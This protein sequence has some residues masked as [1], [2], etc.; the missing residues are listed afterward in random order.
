MFPVSLR[1][2]ERVSILVLVPK[3]TSVTRFLGM[4]WSREICHDWPSLFKTLFQT[5]NMI[6]FQLMIDDSSQACQSFAV[7]VFYPRLLNE[8]SVKLRLHF[9]LC[10]CSTLCFQSW[11]R[12]M[13]IHINITSVALKCNDKTEFL[14]FTTDRDS[15]Q[16]TPYCNMRSILTAIKSFALDDDETARA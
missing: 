5:R 10:W 12:S 4:S 9:L 6:S 3:Y 15:L 8:N 16:T 7:Q 14:P 11:V 1:G 13:F 2:K